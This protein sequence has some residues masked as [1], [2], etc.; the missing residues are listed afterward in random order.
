MKQFYK[1]IDTTNRE[2]M[3]QYLSSHRR[4]YTMNSWNQSTSYANNLKI[5]NLGLTFEQQ[6]KLYKLMNTEDPALYESINDL[7]HSFNC[8]HNWKY[9]VGFNGR[10]D[11]YLVLY[12]GGIKEDGRPFSYPGR[13][14]D[15]NENFK[16]WSDED[17]KDR[18][19]LIEN[20]DKLCDNIVKEAAY[21]ADNYEIEQEEYIAT[22]TVIRKK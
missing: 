12:Q 18:V 13:S 6:S 11:G 19:E 9:Q 14:T 3:I 8:E 21:I 22:R 10:S 1:K 7:C 20:F 4:Y 15:M 2:K 16:E 5:Y 17:L